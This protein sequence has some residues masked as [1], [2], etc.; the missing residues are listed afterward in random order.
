MINEEQFCTLLFAY[1]KAAIAQ[2]EWDRIA[3]VGMTKKQATKEA[4]LHGATEKTYG[5]LWAYVNGGHAK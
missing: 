1:T 3:P 2:D 4:K 5:S